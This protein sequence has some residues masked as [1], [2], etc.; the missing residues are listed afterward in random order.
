MIQL[1]LTK[2][3]TKCGASLAEAAT[4]AGHI[5]LEHTKTGDSYK[6]MVFD[7]DNWMAGLIATDDPA[8]IQ[9]HLKADGTI[10][11]NVQAVLDRVDAAFRNAEAQSGNS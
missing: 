5:A 1:A 2:V 4:Y 10:V 3:F 9:N 7:I 6:W 8:E 11:I